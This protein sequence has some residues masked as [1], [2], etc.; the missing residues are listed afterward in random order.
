[1]IW[2]KLNKS[3]TPTFQKGLNFEIRALMLIEGLMQSPIGTQLSHSCFG[4]SCIT[5][6]V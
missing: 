6:L 2:N 5:L 1:M 4:G 3:L